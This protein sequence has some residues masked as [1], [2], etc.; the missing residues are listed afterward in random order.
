MLD[1]APGTHGRL[2]PRIQY[3]LHKSTRLAFCWDWA[4]VKVGARVPHAWNDPSSA[5]RS[6][7][8]EASCFEQCRADLLRLIK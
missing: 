3:F 7:S 1:L 5:H 2:D 6:R 8:R 4:H